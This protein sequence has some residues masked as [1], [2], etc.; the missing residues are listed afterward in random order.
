MSFRHTKRA[1]YAV[2]AM[3]AL[4][5]IDAGERLSA[6][7]IASRQGIPGRVLPEIMGDLARHGLVEATIGRTGGYRLGRPAADI[8]VS[9]V[10]EAI[11]GDS[12][13]QR[14]VLRDRACTGA[15]TCS[16]H[17]VFTG[18][19]DAMLGALEAAT[20]RDLMPAGS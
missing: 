14:C 20:L 13:R 4:A 12:R 10:V 3:L 15:E 11:E 9:D 2:R 5:E 8:S 6:R 7:R 19:Q 16:A 18:A 17:A 1:D